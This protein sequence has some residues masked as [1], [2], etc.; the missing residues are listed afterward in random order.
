MALQAPAANPVGL[1]FI[2]NTHVVDVNLILQVT[3]PMTSTRAL[4]H[5]DTET[6]TYIHTDKYTHTNK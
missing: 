5:T 2:P 4:W 6:Q 3:Y 1:E